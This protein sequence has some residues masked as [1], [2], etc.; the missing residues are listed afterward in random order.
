MPRYDRKCKQCGR[1]W[2]RVSTIADRMA[3]CETC[4]GEVLEVWK[5]SVQNAYGFVAYWDYGLGREITGLGDRH[6]EM[7]AQHLEYRDKMSKGDMSARHDK[8][9]QAKQEEGRRRA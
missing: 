2:E 3:P 4:G 6:Q 7:R 9:H 1:E 5:P 8:I